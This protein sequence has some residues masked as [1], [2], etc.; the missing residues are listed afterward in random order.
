MPA[1][2][3]ILSVHGDNVLVEVI[4]DHDTPKKWNMKVGNTLNMNLLHE[5]KV[6][7]MNGD[8]TEED[9]RKFKWTIEGVEI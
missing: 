4:V 2:I 6:R 7:L 3:E 8:F 1:S 5:D 9:A